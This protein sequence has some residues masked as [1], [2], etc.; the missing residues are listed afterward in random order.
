MPALNV[1]QGG[2]NQTTT[3]VSIT[4]LDVNDHSPTFSAHLYNASVK[5]NTPDGVP[6]TLETVIDV[7]DGD[8]VNY[9]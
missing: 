5:E 9:P 8:Q 4:V 2:D 1:S 3:V 7:F 6:I